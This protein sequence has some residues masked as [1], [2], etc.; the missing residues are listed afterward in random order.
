MEE[1]GLD[2]MRNNEAC[3]YFH[4]LNV[5]L[6]HGGKQTV[7][8]RFPQPPG[9]PKLCEVMLSVPFPYP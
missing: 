1:L 2:I 4:I 6:G 8:E 9:I 3:I 7:L 5:L